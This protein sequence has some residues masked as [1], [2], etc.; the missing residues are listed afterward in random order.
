MLN[1]KFLPLLGLKSSAQKQTKTFQQF[2]LHFLLYSSILSRYSG[3]CTCIRLEFLIN[4][5]FTL[6]VELEEA[7][8][9]MDIIQS[10]VI[11]K[12]YSNILLYLFLNRP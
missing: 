3:Y 6:K 12:S 5:L 10:K 7:L 11:L 4:F 2:S 1:F 8:S 9:H